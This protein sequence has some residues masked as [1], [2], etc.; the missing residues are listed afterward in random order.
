MSSAAALARIGLAITVGFLGTRVFWVLLRPTLAGPGFARSNYRKHRIATAG[1]ICV[2]AS[3][4]LVESIRA[5]SATVGWGSPLRADHLGV[6]IIVGGFGFLGLVD[7]LG[8]EGNTR[9]FRGHIRALANGSLT[10]GGLKLVGGALIAILVA[11]IDV[12]GGV[13]NHRSIVSVIIDSLTIALGANLANLFDRAPGRTA[14]ISTLFFLVLVGAIALFGSRGVGNS[15]LVSVAV[16]V[17]S[18]LGLLHEELRERV[19]LGD[20]GSNVI[21]AAIGYGLTLA[22]STVTR[23]IVVVILVGLNGVSELVSF[24][25]VIDSFPP[26]RWFDFL[27][28]IPARREDTVKGGKRTLRR[29]DE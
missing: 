6:L 17:G 15:W 26:F 1:G 13:A 4:F 18:T 19:M 11:S 14:K 29:T 25:R 8:A 23:I 16:V 28:A 7:D 24:S 3:V 10:T 22:T 9:G 12:S 2:V 20:T 21:G 27:G 5:L